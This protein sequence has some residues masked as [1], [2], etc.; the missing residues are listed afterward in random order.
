[1]G[2][3]GAIPPLHGRVRSITDPAHDTEVTDFGELMGMKGDTAI[4]LDEQSILQEA[5][6]GEVAHDDTITDIAE[7]H[8]LSLIHHPHS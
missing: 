3:L 8:I 4:V 6:G 1:V 5:T 7:G 2:G